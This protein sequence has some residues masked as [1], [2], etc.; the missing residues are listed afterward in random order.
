MFLKTHRL[1]G[2]VLAFLLPVEEDDLQ[3]RARSSTNGRAARTLVKEG[4]FRITLVALTAETALP[5]HHVAGPVS[6]QTLRGLLQVTLDGEELNVP[7]GG[8]LVLDAGV[9]HTAKAVD[10]SVVMITLSLEKPGV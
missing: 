2:K 1:R 5:S 4:T 9:S 8:L 10:D 3:E 7:Q 6:I